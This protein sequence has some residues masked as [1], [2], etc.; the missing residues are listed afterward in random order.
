MGL[1]TYLGGAV[2]ILAIV[3]ISALGTLP[4]RKIKGVKKLTN[5]HEVIGYLF[6]VAGSI[7]GI[8]LG[9]VVVNSITLFDDARGTVN[10]EGTTLVSL[11]MLAENLPEEDQK[12][13]RKY[14]RDYA[15]SVIRDEWLAMDAGEHHPISRSYAANLFKEIIRVSETNGN[16]AQKMLDL[17][18]DMI[19]ARRERLDIS[20]RSIPG[21]EWLV[22]CVG[23]ILVIL[24]SYMFVTDSLFVQLVGTGMIAIMISLNIYLVVAFGSPFSGNLK[25]SDT[26]FR[27]AIDTFNNIDIIYESNK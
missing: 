15:S 25:V 13:I 16:A 3:L 8:L 2:F 5:H 17:G 20:S 18:Q 6:P 26:A 21:I 23:G 9:L 12:L 1:D 10:A 7:Y 24:F 11:Y 19:E 14:C 27:R 4:I 22:L